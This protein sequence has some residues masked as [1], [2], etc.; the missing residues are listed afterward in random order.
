MEMFTKQKL[1]F[2][3]KKS[4]STGYYA[5]FHTKLA[6]LLVMNYEKNPIGVIF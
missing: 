4:V 6:I 5:K 3:L 1:S 2:H